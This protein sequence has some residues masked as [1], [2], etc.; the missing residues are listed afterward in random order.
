MESILSDGRYKE[1]SQTRMTLGY[2]YSKF[3]KKILRGKSI[4]NSNVDRKATIYSGSQFQDSSLGRFSYVGY[5]C[6]IFNCH[7]G[8][9]CSI[10]N[11]V[12]IVGAKHPL[13]WISTSPVFYNAK[14]G[15]GH[16]IGELQEPSRGQTIVGN[17]VWIGSRA[18]I[19]EGV[20]IGNGAVIG[21]GAVVTKDVP[22]YAIVAG[23]PAKILRYRFDEKLRQRLSES[24]W[25]NLEE[26][27]L[28][29]V[30]VLAESPEK[31]CDALTFH[32]I[33]MGAGG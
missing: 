29:K 3:F 13:S 19:M 14:G 31:F 21:S 16:H 32:K 2:L 8:A 6:D 9:F 23:V 17:D 22:D 27:C 10:A 18:I 11:E 20:K 28:K 1:K 12:I 15:T 7:I 30:A 4:L 24:E 26:E 25:W 33:K 5:D